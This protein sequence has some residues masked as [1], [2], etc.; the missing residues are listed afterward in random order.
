MKS[1]LD[2]DHEFAP[3]TLANAWL[4]TIPRPEDG[5]VTRL[6]QDEAATLVAV[7]GDVL[8]RVVWSIGLLQFVGR[9][10]THGLTA[11]ERDLDVE[12]VVVSLVLSLLSGLALL[13]NDVDEEV[14]AI[15]H[16]LARLYCSPIGVLNVVKS[17]FEQGIHCLVTGAVFKRIEYHIEC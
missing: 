16:Y 12:V 1:K 10:E 11:I 17:L 4:V 13:V 3:S 15:E 6:D 2:L 14:L 8:L 7:L 9:D 5:E